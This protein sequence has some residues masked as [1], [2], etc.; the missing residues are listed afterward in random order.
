MLPFRHGFSRSLL[1]TT[2]TNAAASKYPNPQAANRRRMSGRTRHSLWIEMAMNFVPDRNC[3]ACAASPDTYCPA[4]SWSGIYFSLYGFL[5]NV[6][7]YL[8]T[9]FAL[10][11]L[12]NSLFERL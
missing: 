8:Y 9:H 5:E 6:K 1:F 2:I 7:A 3:P 12:V 10:L 4:P 11:K